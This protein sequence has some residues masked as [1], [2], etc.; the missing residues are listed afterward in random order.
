M[1]TCHPN[2]NRL[3]WRVETC[4]TFKLALPIIVGMLGQNLLGIADVAMIGRVGVT[5]LAACG[6][7]FNISHI[8]LL[9]GLGILAPV[10][11]RSAQAYGA[12]KPGEAAECLR[13]G[14]LLAAACGV[15]MGVSLTMLDDYLHWFRQPAQ[16]VDASH[17]YLLWCGWSLAGVMFSHTIKQYCESLNDPWPP[18]IILLAGVALNILLNWVLIYGNWGAPPLGLEGAGIAT[19]ISRW[20]MAVASVLYVLSATKLIRFRPLEW[21]S[22]WSWVRFKDLLKLGFPICIQHVMEVGA[23]VFG[24]I[25]MGWFGATAMAA[26]QIAIT[27]ASSTFIVA[28]SVGMA[29][30]V[31]VGHVWGAGLRGRLRRIVGGGLVMG[32]GVMGLCA[33]GFLTGGEMIAGWFSEVPEV[34]A[35]TAVL[36]VAAGVFQISDG[37]QVVMMFA[38]RGMSDVRIPTMIAVVS[39]WL[40]SLPVGYLIAFTMDKG[41]IGIWL[42]YLV[43]LTG[44]AVLASIRFRLISRES[45]RAGA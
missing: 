44:V 38:L 37:T 32:V 34:I 4:R 39:Y 12:N 21:R 8:P 30:G 42:G 25:M 41:P 24:A 7:V 23:F 13:H 10:S 26:H 14:L 29:V 28:L 35:L 20:L 45:V 36:F 5:E 43:G 31:R 9:A 19:L 1:E 6:F 40:V 22:N 27:C 33:I 11:I 2:W 16:V 3:R 15:A 17:A 18:M